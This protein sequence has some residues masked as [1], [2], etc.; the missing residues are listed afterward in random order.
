MET[1][2]DAGL[3]TWLMGVVNII[4]GAAIMRGIPWAIGMHS[5]VSAL[6]S[7]VQE[8]KQLRSLFHE[9]DKKLDVVID[10]MPKRKTDEDHQ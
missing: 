4:F 6:K 9:M 5:D 7:D 10:R 2:N 3:L 1:H 8:L